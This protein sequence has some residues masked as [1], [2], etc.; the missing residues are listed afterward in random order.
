MRLTNL[1]IF[2]FKRK[3]VFLEFIIGFGIVLIL[4]VLV[5]FVADYFVKK[6]NYLHFGKVN[7]IMSC[8][9]NE[10]IICFGSSVAEVGFDSKLIG[11]ITNETCYNLGLDGT[12]LKQA[13]PLIKKIINQENKPK[14]IIFIIGFQELN[15]FNKLTAPDRFYAWFHHK[16]I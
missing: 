13:H 8:K 5:S 12:K 4:I 10:E 9:V 14:K 1:S 3:S 16:D 2:N 15:V 11:K 6:S 7:R